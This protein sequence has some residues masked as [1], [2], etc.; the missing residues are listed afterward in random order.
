MLGLTGHLR[1]DPIPVANYLTVGIFFN[2]NY[3]FFI[4]FLF[5]QIK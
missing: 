1:F 4:Y 2:F 5:W 3:L